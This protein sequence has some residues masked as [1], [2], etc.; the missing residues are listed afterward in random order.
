MDYIVNL[1]SSG[2]VLS[3]LLASFTESASIIFIVT[4]A[5]QNWISVLEMDAD[6]A[7]LHDKVLVRDPIRLNKLVISRR[8]FV[9]R[10]Y[11]WAPRKDA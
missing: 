2:R 11:K 3:P 5:R 8:L 7:K 9:Q 4:V 6:D 10:F 1:Q